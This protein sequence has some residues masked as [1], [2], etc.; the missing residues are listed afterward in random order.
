MLLRICRTI[1]ICDID[2]V[3]YDFD[4]VEEETIVWGTLEVEVGLELYQR[5]S[6]RD[7]G[8]DHYHHIGSSNVTVTIEFSATIPEPNN[9]ESF[10][11]DSIYGGKKV[12]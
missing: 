7:P 4:S 12:G 10:E 1:G 9:I 11:V 2:L 8:E 5:N 3:S 6:F